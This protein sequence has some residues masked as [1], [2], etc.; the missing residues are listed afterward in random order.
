MPIWYNKTWGNDN[1]YMSFKKAI[2]NLVLF[3]VSETKFGWQKIY[4]NCFD[5]F[6]FFL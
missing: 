1:Y 2:L 4:K 5:F 3:E 6:T